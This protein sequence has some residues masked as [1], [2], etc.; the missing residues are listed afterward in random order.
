VR[1]ALRPV[2]LGLASVV[3]AAA[4]ATTSPGTAAPTVASIT[5]L[6]MAPGNYG[7]VAWLSSNVLVVE[8]F[9]TV[10]GVV[11]FELLTVGADGARPHLL[12]P[13]PDPPCAS[14][15][16]R[17][18]YRLPDGGIGAV[19]QC[20]PKKTAIVVE[21]RN[22]LVEIDQYGGVKTIASL[23]PVHPSAWG[24]NAVQGDDLTFEVAWKADLSS[25][26]ASDNANCGSIIRLTSRGTE[27]LD[28]EVGPASHRWNLAEQETADPAMGDCGTKFG[29]AGGVSADPSY[30]NIVFFASPRESSD[31]GPPGAAAPGIVCVWNL[32]TNRV[33]SLV[34]SVAGVVSTTWSP[35][36]DWIAFGGNPGG[37][38]D[39]VWLVR[40]TG[41]DL[42][43]ISRDGSVSN[44]AW[45][46]DGHSMIYGI[47]VA[48]AN[49]NVSTVFRRI[50][51]QSAG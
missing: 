1:L 46:P 25:A 51:L 48:G 14:D 47:Y 27:P 41:R 29:S 23:A 37:R 36:G 2:I 16:F 8:R 12:S 7:R 10:H 4:C 13:R 31:G 40:P 11:R 22:T 50:D 42:T 35:T 33:E 6:S 24:D 15:D 38:G 28:L 30:Q 20:I 18:P 44:I 32:R 3:A 45:S 39:G 17:L 19:R 49:G 26:I 34:S 5:T 43:R 21:Q 9:A